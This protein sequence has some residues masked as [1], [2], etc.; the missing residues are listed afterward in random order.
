[1]QGKDAEKVAV[2]QVSRSARTVQKGDVL[3]KTVQV[4][5][6]LEDL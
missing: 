1:M 5:F 4:F 2:F 6:F 3:K